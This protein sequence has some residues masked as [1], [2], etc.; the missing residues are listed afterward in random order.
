MKKSRP[1]SSQYLT[2]TYVVQ[3]LRHGPHLSA[4]QDQM[5]RQP[6]YWSHQTTA[7]RCDM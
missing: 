5:Q 6:V 7:S 4:Q 2:I 3:G 1:F